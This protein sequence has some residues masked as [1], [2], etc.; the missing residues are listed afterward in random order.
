MKIAV[1]HDW[2]TGMR[3]GER[4]L[5]AICEL[6]PSPDIFTLIHK[7][8]SVSEG[9]E[10]NKIYTSFVQRFPFIWKNYRYYLP[11]FPTAIE[12]FDLSAYS[13]IISTSHCVAKGIR[14]PRGSLHVS[15]IHSPMRYIWDLYDDYFSDGRGSLLQRLGMSMF[16]GYL[17]KWDVKSSER[18]NFFIA[19]SRNIAEKIKKY[20]QRDAVVIYPPVDISS[21]VVSGKSDNFYLI[22]SA[23]STYKRIDIA[24]RACNVLQ[25]RLVIIG[26]GPDA[27]RLRSISGKTIEFLGWQKDN[28][29]KDYYSKCR[30]FI[31]PGEEDFGL[32][33]VEAMASG[34]PVIALGK[35]GALESVKPVDGSK[36]PTGLFFYEKKPESLVDA[37]KRFE[38]VDGVFDPQKIREHSINFDKSVFMKR[39]K[40]FMGEKLDA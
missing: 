32:A 23:F 17:Q 38:K 8:G 21:F 1:V 20:Y 35:G 29:L 33:P 34:K 19:N 22:V 9:I 3:G 10:R 25:R 18:V 12:R 24:I 4:V 2:L 39:F 27:L 37:I 13:L 11:L 31:L 6:Y 7:K 16:R 40:E 30:A 36:E 15:Y 26:D 5:G 14:P 28:I